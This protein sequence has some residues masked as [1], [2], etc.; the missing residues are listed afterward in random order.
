V[1]NI[2]MPSKNPEVL[3]R[4]Q[5]NWRKKNPDYRENWRNEHPEKVAEYNKRSLEARRGQWNSYYWANRDRILE[6]QRARR[7][8]HPEKAA[9]RQMKKNFGISLSEKTQLW[10]AQHK[11]CKICSCSITLLSAHIDHVHNSDP[12]IIRGLL[13]GSCNRALGLFK[14]NPAILDR[15]AIYLRTFQNPLEPVQTASTSLG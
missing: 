3:A 1:D 15:A 13:C 4:A 6:K 8:A 2:P 7:A 5:K 9:E 14:D 10:L 12:I 11:K